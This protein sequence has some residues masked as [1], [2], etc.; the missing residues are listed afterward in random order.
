MHTASLL[1]MATKYEVQ[2][3]RKEIL[4]GL[5]VHWP[6]ALGE[7]DAR[8]ARATN[9]DGV[10]DPRRVYTHP[11]YVTFSLLPRR[12]NSLSLTVWS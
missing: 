10:Y 12:F 7:W 4:Q 9:A 5:A 3:L 2:D 1:Q 11:M 8:E 6:H